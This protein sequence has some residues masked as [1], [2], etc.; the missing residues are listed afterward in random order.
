MFKIADIVESVEVEVGAR[1]YRGLEAD[2]MG[3]LWAWPGGRL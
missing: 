1:V 2:T 3:L